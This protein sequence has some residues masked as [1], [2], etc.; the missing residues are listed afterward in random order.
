LS[1]FWSILSTTIGDW[2]GDRAQRL[3]AALAYY[4]VFALA[5]TI[6]IVIAVAAI[7]L[8]HEAAR[9]EILRQIHELVGEQ[10][11]KAVES[12]IASA[13]DPGASS[14]AIGLGLITLVFGL[15]GVFGELQDALNTIWGVTPKA[16]RGVLDVIRQR[17]WS[18]ALVV[19]TGFLLLVSL[20]ISTWISML[21]KYFW[22]LLPLPGAALQAANTVVSFGVITMLFALTFKLLPDV[23]IAWRDV[24]LGAAVT[25]LLFT[26]GKLVIGLYL[27]KS[28]VASAFGAAGS[29]VVILVWVYYSAQILYFGA[30]FTKVWT[31]RR[32]SGFTPQDNAEPVTAE[33]RAE[34]GLGPTPTS[35]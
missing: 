32:G 11:A 21:T 5:P 30:E 16:G 6:V 28:G 7:V 29:L 19:G 18:F 1:G 4:T 13:R 26:I 17:F 33:A 27:G 2:Y 34:Q 10:G 15:W 8:G 25:A 9:D 31:R 20:A 3:G 14:K 24:W 22:Y 23:D 12:L 35:R